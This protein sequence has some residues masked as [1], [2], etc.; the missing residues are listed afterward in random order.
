VAPAVIVFAREPIAGQTKTR[1]I[2]AIGAEDCA[3]LADA[4]I[5][6]AMQK[7]AAAGGRALVIAGSSPGPIADSE[8]FRRLARSFSAELVD[9]GKG[10][11]GQRMARVLAPYAQPPGA[12][13][14]GTDIPTLPALYIR[15]NMYALRRKPV[16]I[17]PTLDGG[18]YLV[19]VSG[20][21]P[22]IFSGIDWGTDKVM[23]QSLERIRELRIDYER[24]PW[25]VDIDLPGDLELLAVELRRG[26]P[27]TRGRR[28][29]CPN[30]V[31][32]MEDWGLIK[33]AAAAKR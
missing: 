6:D 1:L 28:A 3:R 29:A 10:D 19:G 31:R 4:F 12:V 23:E 32:L 5:K 33:P 20:T 24:G 9:Q 7:A 8:Y 22:N 2:P 13:L 18:Y 14:F 11:L 17:A 16:V 21:V 27:G 30:T 26:G 15:Q 25:W